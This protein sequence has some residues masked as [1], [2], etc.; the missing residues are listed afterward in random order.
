VPLAVA[1]YQIAHESLSNIQRHA[2]AGHVT[3]RLASSNNQGRL[4]ISDDG[5][6]FE[7]EKSQAERHRGLRNIGARA[8]SV[9]AQVTIDSAPGKGTT[10]VVTFPLSRDAQ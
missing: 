3:I 7:P 8:R 2:R 10:T 5:I 9:G 6:G 4:E 1:L